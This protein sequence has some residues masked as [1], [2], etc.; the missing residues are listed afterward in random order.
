MSRTIVRSP[1]NG[2]LEDLGSG[3]WLYAPSKDFSG[4]DSFDWV[5][6]DDDGDRSLEA[7]VTL[8][9]QEQPDPPSVRLRESDYDTNVG[10][11]LDI[12][13]IVTDPDHDAD[14]FEIRT[15][16]RPNGKFIPSRGTISELAYL[17]F[18]ATKRGVSTYAVEVR[19]HSGLTTRA[20]FTIEV[21]NTPPVVEFPIPSFIGKDYFRLLTLNSTSSSDSAIDTRQPR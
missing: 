18:E 19:D 20:T 5:A 17:R 13:A 21:T 14:W 7:T 4:Y 12:R 15:G 3:R 6:I 1:S 9:V 16:A 2:T 10:E 8:N 11:Q